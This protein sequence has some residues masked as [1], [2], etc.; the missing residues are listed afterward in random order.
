VDPLHLAIASIPLAL[1]FIVLGAINLMPRPVLTT[2]ARDVLALSLGISGF[3]IAGPMELF[4]PERAAQTFGPYVWL[5]MIVLYLLTCLLVALMGRPRLI[6]YN[7]TA[8]E[9]RPI[10]EATVQSIDPKASW[11]DDTYVLPQ[12]SVQFHVEQFPA[13][14]NVSLVSIGPRQSWQS[15]RHL[16]G[17]LGDALRAHRGGVN[18]YGLTLVVFGI[19]LIAAATFTLASGQQPIVQALRDMLRL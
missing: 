18:P 3:V 2:G 7:V 6:I 15:W 17:V 9:L 8:L 1:Y 19:G 4:L 5:L 13:L 12:A 11:A 10:L 16:E 14:R